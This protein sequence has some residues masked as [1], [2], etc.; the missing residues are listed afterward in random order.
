VV[1]HKKTNTCTKV[2]GRKPL[3]KVMNFVA[4]PLELLGYG[5]I[6]TQVSV[7]GESMGLKVIYYDVEPK[8]AIGK[9]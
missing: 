8:L 9:C 7:M 1:F 5:H 2:T 6:G 4:K 3:Q